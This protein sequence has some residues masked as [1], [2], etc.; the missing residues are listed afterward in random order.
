MATHTME[1]EHNM[2]MLKKLGVPVY[3]IKASH[4][5]GRKAEM[6][7]ATEAGL[8]KNLTLAPGARVMLR[9]NMW[10]KMGLTNGS[11]GTVTG[12]IASENDTM[13]I[14]VLV[15]FPDYKGPA[16]IPGDP[17]IVPVPPFTSK[18]GTDKSLMRTTIPLSLAWAITIHKSQG[19]TY[20]KAAVNLGDKE[21][22]VGLTY[23]A[24][25]RVKKATGLLM[26]GNY[27]EDR[28]MGINK[29]PKHQE[30]RD[31]EHWLDS[32]CHGAGMEQ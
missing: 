1:D 27:S 10:T 14:C 8:P 13:P 21:L 16:A 17:S 9:T 26:K 4:A 29:N 7:R 18:F 19:Q 22:S 3:K 31:A 24:L 2:M 6:A 32:L 5:G 23:V 11:M 20:D 28:I 15:R 12:V 25:S 30:R